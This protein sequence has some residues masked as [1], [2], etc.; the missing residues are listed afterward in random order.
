[1]IRRHRDSG[2][3]LIELVIALAVIVLALVALMS[4]VISS[5][6]ISDTSKESALAYEAARAKIE[7]MRTYTKCNTFNNI[8]NYYKYGQTANTATVTGLNA[9]KSGGVAK[10]VLQIHFP[11]TLAK[12]H[13]SEV[14]LAASPSDPIQQDLHEIGVQLGMPK[15]LDRNGSAAD[16][17]TFDATYGVI[18]VMVR[19][20]WESVGKLP[21]KIEVVTYITEK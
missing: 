3:S 10:P 13:L 21:T 9:I 2:I 8:F 14:L 7:E 11:T 5:S 17:A 1:M 12:D 4:S 6:K 18:P 20:Q 19:V 15:D 16:S